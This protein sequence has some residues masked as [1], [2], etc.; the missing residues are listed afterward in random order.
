MRTIEIDDEVYGAL[1]DR[2]VAFEDA[3]NDVLRRL[4]G[5]RA[6]NAAA[7]A[8][9]API[10]ALP[11]GERRRPART[12][13]PRERR[14][15]PSGELMPMTAYSP[16][17]LQALYEAGGEMRSRDLPEKLAPL[18]EP[19]LQAAD[20]VIDDKGKPTWHSRIGWAGSNSRKEGHLDPNAPRGV[21]RL[22]DEGRAAAAAAQI[23]S[24]LAEEEA[25]E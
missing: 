18:V 5:L 16:F 8:G 7:G 3:P 14:R 1:Q 22:T 4:F 21:W 20:K 6:T 25:A 23:E 13:E 15:R 10:P 19:H 12:A 17:I 9:S 24:A 2:A 11:A